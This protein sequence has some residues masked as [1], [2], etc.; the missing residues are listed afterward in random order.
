MN[1]ACR[2]IWHSLWISALAQ[3]G[4]DSLEIAMNL[5]SSY[6]PKYRC[7]GEWTVAMALKPNPAQDQ[8]WGALTT[9]ALAKDD[10]LNKIKGRKIFYTYVIND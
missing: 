7:P 4:S 10:V 3:G 1:V 5:Y 9:Q 2:L 8:I 6:L